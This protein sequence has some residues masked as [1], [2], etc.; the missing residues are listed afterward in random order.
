[1]L[2]LLISLCIVDFQRI[3]MDNNHIFMKRSL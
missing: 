1:M 2:T 3:S